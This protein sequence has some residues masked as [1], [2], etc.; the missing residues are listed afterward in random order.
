MENNRGDVVEREM[1]V[2]IETKN[3]KRVDTNVCLL[4]CLCVCFWPVG[5]SLRFIMGF[6]YPY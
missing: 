1:W 6:V 3:E 5:V 4:V 2:Q